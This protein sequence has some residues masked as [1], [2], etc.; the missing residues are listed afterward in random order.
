MAIKL[1]PA[2]DEPA[3]IVLFSTVKNLFDKYKPSPIEPKALFS[4]ADSC[5]ISFSRPVIAFSSPRDKL[6]S[7]TNLPNEK[8]AISLFSLESPSAVFLPS[9]LLLANFS[10][11]SAS[12]ICA[13]KAVT[14]VSIDLKVVNST[15]VNSLPSNSALA[16][17]SE[18]SFLFNACNWRNSTLEF[19]I[20]LFVFLV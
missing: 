19:F 13:S 17:K 5:N 15:V 1:P 10:L 2:V 8:L 4:L 20:I 14:S 7:R 6:N 16:T 3:L 11:N 9:T 12:L 18:P